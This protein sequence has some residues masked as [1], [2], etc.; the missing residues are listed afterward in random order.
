MYKCAAA[1]LLALAPGVVQLADAAEQDAW[2]S[3]ATRPDNFVTVDSSTEQWP[4]GKIVVLEGF[5][6]SVEEDEYN[7][8]LWLTVRAS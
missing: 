5:I 8:K 4:V 7:S 2:T 3:C 6:E 1:V